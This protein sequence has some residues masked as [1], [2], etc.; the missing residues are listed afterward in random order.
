MVPSSAVVNADGHVWWFDGS[1]MVTIEA[2]GEMVNAGWYS[3]AVSDWQAGQWSMIRSVE[4]CTEPHRFCSRMCAC[5]SCL[6]PFLMINYNSNGS[7]NSVHSGKV[8]C[9]IP[10]TPMWLWVKT[11]SKWSDYS[12]LGCWWLVLT[13]SRLMIKEP[14]LLS[15]QSFLFIAGVLLGGEWWRTGG[16]LQ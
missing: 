10:M 15:Q 13:H 16:Q 1:T 6:P 5:V 14:I 7:L 4:E 3:L 2:F 12:F 9:I 11:S 8:D